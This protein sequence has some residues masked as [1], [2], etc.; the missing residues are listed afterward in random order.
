MKNQLYLVEKTVRLTCIWAPTG[1][2]RRP[3][4]CVWAAAKPPAISAATSKA[5]TGRIHRCA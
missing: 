5:N 4:N 1:D 3:L 2:A